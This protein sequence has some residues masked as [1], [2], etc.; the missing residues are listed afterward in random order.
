AADVY[1]GRLELMDAASGRRIATRTIQVP[2]AQPFLF[3]DRTYDAAAALL[4][5]PARREPVAFDYGIRGAG[6]LRFHLQGIGRLR[7]SQS[8]DDTRRAVSDFETACRMEPEAAVTR[9]G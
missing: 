7:A 5:L 2:A 1:R 8:P 9:A 6:T 3:L 4:R